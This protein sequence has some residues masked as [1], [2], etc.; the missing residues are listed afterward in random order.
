MGFIRTL[1]IR[2]IEKVR[3]RN[4]ECDRL[5]ND[6]S[7]ALKEINDLLIDWQ[8]F[9]EPEEEGNWKKKYG[10]LL[11][12]IKYNNILRMK[13]ASHYSE[14]VAKQREIYSWEKVLKHQI[15]IHNDRV[16]NCKIEN[17]YNLVGNVEGRQLDRQQ[18]TCIVKEVHNQL[19]I[20]GAGTGK[21]TTIVGK[22]KYLLQMGLCVPEDILVLSYTKASASEMSQRINEETGYNIAAM[23]FHK[24]GKN[25]I[26]KVNGVVPQ[27]LKLNVCKYIK[28]QI[29]LCMKSEEYLK[30]LNIY[31]LYN[32]VAAKSE[33][34][35]KT[36]SEY[37]EYLRLN[38]PITI[39]NEKVKSYGEMDIANFLVQNG[40]NY[41]YEQPYEIDTRTDR[42]GQYCPDF[43]L[44]DYHIYI[45]YFGVDRKGEVPAYFGVSNGMTATEAYKQSME[46]K[47]NLHRNNNT[48][49][50]ECY[51]YEKFEG[52]LLEN[53]KKQ[54]QEAQ[55]AFAPKS[56]KELWEQ[57]SSESAS[58]I[59]GM[60]ELF[61]IVINHIKSNNYTFDMVRQLNARTNKSSNNG[62]LLSLIEPIYDAYC[63]YL[64][65]KNEIDFNDMI[66]IASE[67]ITR[68]K[69]INTYKYVIVDEYQDISRAR[70][71]LLM[72]MR[73][74]N[75]FKLFCV[76]DD[77]QS[78]YRF[79][80]SDIRCILN[81][82][83][84]WGASE[85]SKIETTYRFSKSL[86]DVS[87]TFI[88]QN[89]SQIK[90][91]IKGKMVDQEFALGEINGYTDEQAIYY[92]TQ[93]LNEL[94]PNSS[95][96]FIGRYGFDCR[97]VENGKALTC[98]YNKE[99]EFEDVIYLKRP[100]L[101]ISFMTAHKS[102]GLQADYVFV[103]NN[104][105]SKRGF[106]SKIQDAD[107]IEL[108]LNSY[109][110]YPYEEERRLFYV[111]LTR[112][113]KKVFL[114][115]VKGQES[116]FV[117]ELRHRYSE[118]LKK[119]PYVCPKCGGRMIKKTGQYGEFYGCSN[120]HAT[121]C[122]FKRKSLTNTFL[123]D[124]VYQ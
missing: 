16:A 60:A 64:K 79:S 73:E 63:S 93:V 97:I 10:S 30:L 68:G 74:S 31:L 23:T 122:D 27:I 111:A 107:I 92:L 44:P 102:K 118:Q 15:H 4:N 70:Y 123:Y 100:D 14:L 96:F 2:H 25:I 12:E 13:K 99:T 61:E 115:T 90:K 3:N 52:N 53:L 112:A 69:Y 106:P 34:E 121:Q 40:I 43:Y 18:M 67:Y 81:F 87:G 7:I 86:I 108:L 120:Y 83:Q 117:M 82:E 42:F 98:R 6:T 119:D 56:P 51:A 116:E 20:A 1:I 21:T 54:L 41:I 47:R 89:P 39:N 94:P 95:V 55:V 59:D 49:M 37:E 38:P 46:W 75:D 35:F 36:K 9:I 48:Y 26:T 28:E 109:D 11:A 29:E 91:A 77:W 17:A 33:F 65:E 8:T 5:I 19:V 84:Y 85:I 24:L 62:V 76:G 103:I 114:V 105:N 66:N 124:K 110:Q 80:G 88:M 104:K 22:I 113:R 101:K 32:R 50:I 45:E 71:A 57:L 58:V 78:I 72:S